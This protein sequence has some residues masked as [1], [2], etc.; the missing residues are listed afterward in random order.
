[1]LTQRVVEIIGH[2]DQMTGISLSSFLTILL[3][4]GGPTSYGACSRI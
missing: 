4:L 3:R 2:K 1:M